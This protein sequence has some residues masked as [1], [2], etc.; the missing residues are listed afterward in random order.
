[1]RWPV[2]LRRI[3]AYFD[4]PD[5]RLA[6]AASVALIIFGNQPFY[7]LYVY[8]VVGPKAWPSMLTWISAPFFAAVPWL[9][10]RTPLKGVLI[11]MSASVANTYVTA[12]A[13]GTGTWVELFYVP[14]AALA[15]L[16]LRKE[17]ARVGYGFCLGA[18]ALG[19]ALAHGGSGSGLV[20]LDA[21][22]LK[23]LARINAF[24]VVSLLFVF[25]IMAWRIRQK[26]R[27]QSNP[28]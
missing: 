2:L 1:V 8:A 11:L 5:P 21:S 14:C 12:M 27:A 26:E 10:R 3:G 4:N 17:Q 13:L 25:A 6:A 23:S 15:P 16:L 9:C 7:P 24:S 20:A 22:E 19:L 28:V 18:I